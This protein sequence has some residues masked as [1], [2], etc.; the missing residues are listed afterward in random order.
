MK[1]ERTEARAVDGAGARA[2][3]QVVGVAKSRESREFIQGLSN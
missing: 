2:N 1:E 3:C